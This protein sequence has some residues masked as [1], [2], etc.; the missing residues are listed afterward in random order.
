[1]CP[2]PAFRMSR[3]RSGSNPAKRTMPRRRTEGTL[4]LELGAGAG[5]LEPRRR[6][7]DA[8]GGV[9]RTTI[10]RSTAA[11]G[12][13]T[14]TSA[15]FTHLIE[16][17]GYHSCRKVSSRVGLRRGFA[18]S[19]EDAQARLEAGQS[20]GVPHQQMLCRC[21]NEVGEAVIKWLA[22]SLQRFEG[23]WPTILSSRPRRSALGSNALL[24]PD[25]GSHLPGAGLG[26]VD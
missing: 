16:A 22:N 26:L 9:Y 6:G 10:I 21:S 24:A 23:A 7:P 14:P 18:N 15:T 25:A 4:P 8:S 1:M 5:R 20:G 13:P 12:A 17:T 2:A 19:M 11:L 3:L